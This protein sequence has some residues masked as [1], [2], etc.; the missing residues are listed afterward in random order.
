MFENDLNVVEILQVGVI[1]LGFLLA[2]L[3]YHLLTKEQ[4]QDTPRSV[5]INSIYVFMF[6][7][8]VLCV[9][10]ILSQ[11]ERFND[12]QNGN[13]RLQVENSTP[14]TNKNNILYSYFGYSDDEN[15][16]QLCNIS[17]FVYSEK[18]INTDKIYIEGRI[19]GK[20]TV[21]NKLIDFEHLAFGYKNQYYL[22]IIHDEG[23]AFLERKMGDYIGYWIG[24][25]DDP[26][27]NAVISP[28]VF[29]P[30][31]K[32]L[33]AEEAKEKWPILN[34]PCRILFSLKEILK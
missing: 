26:D 27:V 22:K 23:V 24:E 16:I 21:D 11:N 25:V 33:S 15:N 29:S 34:K 14:A 8:I 9:I 19:N 10:G 13:N 3:A 32:G 20:V 2:V 4:K 5:I 31:A 7:S 30:N 1:G 18:I 12:K 28:V 6:F 17:E